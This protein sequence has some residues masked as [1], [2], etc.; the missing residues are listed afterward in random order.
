MYSAISSGLR[1]GIL[2]KCDTDL[3]ILSYFRCQ[4]QHSRLF[5][6]DFHVLACEYKTIGLQ[7]GRHLGFDESFRGFK[8]VVMRV[9]SF[10]G[11]TVLIHCNKY[12]WLKLIAV[13]DNCLGKAVDFHTLQM[14]KLYRLY[15]Y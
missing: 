12:D 8:L 9:A 13:R 6:E 7:C 10:S 1:P 14:I 3:L 15:T 4:H 5:W 11:L 2:T